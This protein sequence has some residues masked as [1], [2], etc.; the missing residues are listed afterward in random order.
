MKTSL[1]V[2]SENSQRFKKVVTPS[3]KYCDNIIINEIEGQMVAGIGARDAS[4]KILPENIKRICKSFFDMGAKDNVVI[5]CP[6][7]GF[8]LDNKGGFYTVPSHELPKGYIKGKVGA[9]DA[10]CAGILYALYNGMG[11][12]ESLVLANCAAECNLSKE[13]S[14]SGMRS[15]AE[16]MKIDKLY[17]RGKLC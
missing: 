13:D 12:E 2:V 16:T 14:I 10:F 8:L 17:K 7:A 6:E 1:D 9:G 11:A 5:H 4:G 3:V 15:Y